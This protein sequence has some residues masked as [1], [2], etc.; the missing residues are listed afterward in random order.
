MF[1]S[2]LS[3][4]FE[5]DSRLGFSSGLKGVEWMFKSLFPKESEQDSCLTFPSGTT[6]LLMGSFASSSLQDSLLFL[7]KN[8]CNLNWFRLSLLGEYFFGVLD[9]VFEKSSDSADSAILFNSSG[10][11]RR[12]EVLQCFQRRVE[13]WSRASP[14]Q[15]ST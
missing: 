2:L 11:P 12:V 13:K 10:F 3:D 14:F 7:S 9:L 6:C 8:S 1:K 4:E 5:Q 15:H